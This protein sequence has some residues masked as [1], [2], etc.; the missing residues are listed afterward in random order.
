MLQFIGRY[1]IYNREIK[2]KG[3]VHRKNICR[4]QKGSMFSTQNNIC[5]RQ[6]G[7]MFSTQNNIC[8]RQNG[9][10]FST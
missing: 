6:K 4:R 8:R 3:S 5:R 2:M 9:S 1:V 10:M 7:S